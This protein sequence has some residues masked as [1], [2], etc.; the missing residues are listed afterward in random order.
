MTTK[1][2]LGDVL[3]SQKLISKE[4]LA[5]ALKEQKEN[6]GFLGQIL[7]NKGLVSPADISKA[8]EGLSSKIKEHSSLGQMLVKEGVVSQKQLE[9]AISRQQ[10]TSKNLVDVLL[11]SGTV[12][13]AEISKV[14]SRYLG[15]PYVEIS[16][17]P[18]PG[19]VL[20]LIP[21]DVIRK[22]QVIPLK[23]EG[24]VL[25]LAVADPLNIVVLE[26]V[27]LI[28]KYK[29]NPVVASLRDIK[30]LIDRHF[31]IQQTA[32]QMFS[33]IRLEKI[34]DEGSVSRLVDMILRAGMESRA[35]DIHLEPQFPE[36]RVR[37]RIDGILHNIITIPK[38]IEPSVVSRIKVLA[39]MDI[40]EH[41]RPQDGHISLKINEKDY[42]LRVAS[43]STV[44]GEKV[45]IRILDKSNMLFGLD[46]LGLF[47]SQ[48]NILRSLIARPYGIILITGPTGSGKTTSLYAIIN[49]MDTLTKN[50]ITIEDPVEYRIE[51]INQVQVNPVADI[52]FARGL[53]SILRQDPDIIMVGE[54]RDTETANIAIHAALTG[55]LVFSTLHTN[56]A[57][58]AVSR[59]I[60]MGV[61]PFL[62]ASSLIG[63]V[64][65]RLV[66]VICPSCR[67]KY[68]PDKK[69][70]EDMGLKKESK[71]ISALY[72]GRGCQNCLDTGYK[73]RSGIFEVMQVSEG[74]RQMITQKESTSNIRDLAVKEGMISLR[75]SAIEN[76]LKGATSVKE[77]NRVIYS[78]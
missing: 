50:I 29:V 34:S 48:Q 24:D 35:S 15:L 65:Q 28:S 69:D 18:I 41:R 70:I 14:L 8:L 71:K 9:D 51:G 55:H 52:T 59:L 46:E 19:E 53:R 60:D 5:S 1:N 74:L 68:S 4:D 37:F 75:Q 25:S 57:P 12:D 7:I 33:D 32:K 78:S 11:E 26:E 31:N 64:A 58:S 30:D 43:S 13:S 23:L 40:T 36:M 63:V 54:I 38:A 49:Q 73:G 44:S 67:E 6:G 22:Y 77:A 10:G 27:R 72:R 42:D 21:E 16:Q 66:R 61:E 47:S 56:D 17:T 62:I 39:D 45:V 20:N 2:R 3:I 76:V